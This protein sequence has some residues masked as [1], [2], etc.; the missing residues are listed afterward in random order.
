M[1]RILLIVLI[2][3]VSYNISRAQIFQ[4]NNYH[5]FSGKFIISVAGGSAIGVTDYES[6]RP[7]LFG[8]GSLVYFFN[9]NSKHALG[10]KVYGGLGNLSGNDANK[11]PQTFKTS[12]TFGGGGL[13][14]SYY[15]SPSFI[16][17]LFGGIAN[18][19]YSPK[20]NNGKII[21]YGSNRSNSLTEVI[22][23]AQIGFHSF[24]SDRFGI[25]VNLGYNYGKYDLLDGLDNTGQGSDNFFTASI[26]VTYSLFSSPDTETD[27]DNDGVPDIKDICPDT[28]LGAKVT[29]DGCPI[30]SDGDGVPDYLDQCLGTPNGVFADS[31]GCPMDSDGDGV[32]DYLDKCPGTPSGAAI[33]DNGCKKAEEKIDQE[34]V[35]PKEQ[36]VPPKNVNKPVSKPFKF[37]DA[38][39]EIN[40]K[41]NIWTDGNQYVIQISS[42][43]TNPKAKKVANYWKARGHNAFVQKTYVSKY[44]RTYFRVRIGYFTSLEEAEAYSRK[45]R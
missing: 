14:Y 1:K 9:I 39:H 7:D 24:I 43:K 13:V 34:S 5:P 25:N 36:T 4:K 44:N 21:P 31:N 41:N 22:Y 16:P 2:V 17:Y 30:D 12:F 33:D 28:P 27:T 42:W 45:L 38:S 29:P 23:N 26:G 18:L 6:I 19:W 20:D 35:E 37:Y 11:N 10:F 8:M 15:I 3:F 32:P 40:I